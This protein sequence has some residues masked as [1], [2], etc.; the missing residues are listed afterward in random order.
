MND[1]KSNGYLSSKISD[2]SYSSSSEISSSYT[3]DESGS[4]IGSSKRKKLN[5]KNKSEL[6]KGK[7]N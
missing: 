2:L 4:L 1:K 6:M 3:D 7:R 5:R